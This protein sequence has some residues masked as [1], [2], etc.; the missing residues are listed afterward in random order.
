MMVTRNRHH[1]K[2]RRCL[3]DPRGRPPPTIWPPVRACGALRKARRAGT[4]AQGGQ[5]SE[6]GTR[7]AMHT[8]S[9]SAAGEFTARASALRLRVNILG[10]LALAA[11]GS[12]ALLSFAQAPA[13]WSGHAGAPRAM[14]FFEALAEHLSIVTLAGMFRGNT[15]VIVSYFVPLAVATVAAV[16]LVAVLYRRRGALD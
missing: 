6:I 2:Y 4:N 15:T 5:T 9:Q 12:M 10:A 8:V 1:N 13:L 7:P 11:Y 16:L 3:F 14:A